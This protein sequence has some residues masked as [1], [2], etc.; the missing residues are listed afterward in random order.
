MLVTVLLVAALIISAFLILVVYAIAPIV[1]IIFVV[2]VP[3]IIWLQWGFSI[4][5]PVLL[6][7][8]VIFGVLFLVNSKKRRD[9]EKW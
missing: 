8:L 1:T 5:L 4:A 2:L 7:Q 3:I 9:M 6:Y